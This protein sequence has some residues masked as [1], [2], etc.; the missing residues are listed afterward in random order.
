MN[1]ARFLRTPLDDCFYFTTVADFAVTYSWKLSSGE[2]SL[3]RKKMHISQGFYRFRFFYTYIYFL[4]NACLPC[5][6]RKAYAVLWAA[7]LLI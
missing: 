2:R 4:T 1:F 6:L 3:V 7:V 5:R